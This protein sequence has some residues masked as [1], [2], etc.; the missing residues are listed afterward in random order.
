MK[1]LVI[2]AGPTASGK[3]S[4]AVA[5]A[6]K[7]DGEIISADSMQVYRRMDIGSAKIRPEEMQGVPHHLIDILDP[8]EDFNVSLFQELVKEKA[9]EIRGRGRLPILAGGTGFYIQSVLYD[10]PFGKEETDPALRERLEQEAERLGTD[11]MEERLKEKDPVSALAY[12]GNRKRIIRALEY[13]ELTGKLLSDKNRE[14]RMR[15]TAYDAA[16]FCLTM[17]REI[18]YQRIDERVDQMMK[19]GLLEEVK[20]LKEEGVRRDATSMQGLGYRQL[21]D[22]LEGRYPLE[23]AVERI[24]RETRHFA[25]RQL[26]WFKREKNVIWLDRSEFRDEEAILERMLTGL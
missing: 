19:D 8:S 26:T 1:E 16:F 20:S 15:P 17:P 2:I 6:K 7:T 22:H 12:H 25:K 5:L 4:L 9:A 18:L 10:I 23:E 13:H 3:S 14:E 11:A 21:Y 24:K